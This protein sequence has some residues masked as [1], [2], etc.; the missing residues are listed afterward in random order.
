MAR[1][2][3]CRVRL[4]LALVLTTGLVACAGSKPPPTEPSKPPPSNI[5][6]Q[7]PYQIYGIWYYPLP[8]AEGYSEKGN[9]SW[10]GPGFH[11]RPTAN[12]ETYDMY[13]MTAAHKVLPIGT[14]VKV[15]NLKNNRSIIVRVND[16]GPFVS[17]RIID[18][19]YTA[20]ETLGMARTGVVPVQVEAVQLAAECAVAALW[21]LHHPG[22]S[23]QGAPERLSAGGQ[24]GLP[25]CGAQST[26]RHGSLHP[27]VSG[28][29]GRL[30]RS[31]ARQNGNGTSAATGFSRR[32]CGRHGELTHAGADWLSFRPGR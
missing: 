32:L 4:L 3:Q 1:S 13:A 9:A 5:R 7:R 11:A 31:G 30:R 26:Q 2:L 14:H 21:P 16:R 23:L 22:G 18:L 8:T 19:S 29:G 12:G 6:T 20:A 15:T 28:A 17:G 10:Y 25:L 27:V 24:D